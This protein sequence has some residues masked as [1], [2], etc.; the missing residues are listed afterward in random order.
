[1]LVCT[2][3]KPSPPPAPPHCRHR[4][5]SRPTGGQTA[6]HQLNTS[7]AATSLQ[8]NN[9][10]LFTVLL[11]LCCTSLNTGD[12]LLPLRQPGTFSLVPKVKNISSFF[13]FF[14][15]LHF[16]RDLESSQTNVALSSSLQRLLH[17]CFLRSRFLLRHL[18]PD[19][20]P[21]I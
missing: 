5:R 3:T 7:A 2:E 11:F 12:T 9:N 21:F 6:Q 16:Q 1:M 10:C 4:P 14:F 20:E 18:T 15:L 13:C 17:C 8:Y 19:P